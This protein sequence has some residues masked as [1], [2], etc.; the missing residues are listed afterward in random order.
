MS[1][2]K[3]NPTLVRVALAQVGD[4]S[5]W[6]WLVAR[7]RSRLVSIARREAIE[8]VRSRVDVEDLVQEMLCAIFRGLSHARFSSI[9][10]FEGWFVKVGRHRVIDLARRGRSARRGAAEGHETAMT[11]RLDEIANSVSSPS[12]AAHR[13]EAAE[14]LRT[15]LARL[16]E[17]YR[18]VLEQVRLHHRTTAEVAARLG[19]T[20]AAVRKRLERALASC[21]EIVEGGSFRG[22]RPV[23]PPRGRFDVSEPPAR[24]DA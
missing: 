13:R 11:S 19:L 24:L 12:R 21:R 9:E 17:P 23:P 4:R 22:R 1:V 5:A 10:G 6:E 18:D 15:I 3:P 7:Y 14:E 8:R 2:S 16:P 20:R